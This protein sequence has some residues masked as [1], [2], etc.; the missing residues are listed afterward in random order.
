M[1][2]WRRLTL[3]ERES[4]SATCIFDLDALAAG[5][6]CCVLPDR[7]IRQHFAVRASFVLVAWSA[8]VQF[9][10]AVYPLGPA[11]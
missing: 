4:T 11:C 2:T 9:A 3:L 8:E 1:W 7:W 10:R 5:T 6:S